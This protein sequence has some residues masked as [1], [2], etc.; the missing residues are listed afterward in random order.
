[1][2]ALDYLCWLPY[3]YRECGIYFIFGRSIFNNYFLL[4]SLKEKMNCRYCCNNKVST[5]VFQEIC[6]KYF[7]FCQVQKVKIRFWRT[8]Y[9]KLSQSTKLIWCEEKASGRYTEIFLRYD[10][11]NVECCQKNFMYVFQI[12][13][14]RMQS[15]QKKV[16]EAIE[17]IVDFQENRWKAI[18][19]SRR[20]SAE[21]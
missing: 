18:S 19:Y 6:D 5:N 9:I 21:T 2:E 3:Q 10:I 20:I 11:F 15:I 13:Q 8:T 17:G 4:P 1:M 14:K 16:I 12:K 7:S